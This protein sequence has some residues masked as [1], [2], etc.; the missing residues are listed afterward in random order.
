MT[1]RKLDDPESNWAQQPCRDPSHDPPGMIVLENGLWEHT[2]PSCKKV[3]VFR[4]ERPT[5]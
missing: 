1:L 2:C 5:L 3:T 4:V